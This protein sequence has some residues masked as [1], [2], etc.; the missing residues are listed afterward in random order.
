MVEIVKLEKG[1]LEML[2]SDEKLKHYK[3]FLT[4]EAIA[5]IESSR[6]AFTLKVNEKP[7]ACMGVQEYWRGRG[8]AWAFFVPGYPEYFTRIH[9]AVLRFLREVKIRRI[10]ATVRTAF[11]EGQKWVLML[12]FQCERHEMKYWGPTGESYSAYS[13]LKGGDL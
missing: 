9:R 8:E 3:T 1:D 12:G 10:E 11:F 4:K 6:Y 2:L 7:I 5:Q 13:Y